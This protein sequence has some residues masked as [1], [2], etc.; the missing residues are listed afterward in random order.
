[1]KSGDYIKI[2]ETKDGTFRFGVLSRNFLERL[3]KE[4]IKPDDDI[5]YKLCEADGEM[6]I[7]ADLN[8]EIANMPTPLGAASRSERMPEIFL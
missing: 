7:I 1:M 6:M 4:C 2:F 5:T 8:L 3:I